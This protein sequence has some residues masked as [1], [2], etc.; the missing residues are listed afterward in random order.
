MTDFYRQRDRLAGSQGSVWAD[1]ANW[2]DGAET[3][4]LNPLPTLADAPVTA[5][6]YEM[7]A[8]TAQPLYGQGS[9]RDNPQLETYAV[10]NED[11]AVDATPKVF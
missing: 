11:T 10:V 3:V 1:A 5:A 4:D 9:S 8:E 2:T 6:D 7:A